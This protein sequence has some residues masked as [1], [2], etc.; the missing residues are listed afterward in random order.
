MITL[1]EHPLSPYSRKVKIALAEKG[2]QADIL[3]PDAFGTGHTAGLFQQASPRGEVPALVLEDGTA[4]FGSA[5]MMDY[6][7][8]RW[9]SPP[10]MPRDPLERARV[11]MIEEVVDTQ[12]EAIHWGLMEL[13]VFKRAEGA[14]A[15]TLDA[16]AR[17]QIDGIHGWLERQLG[18]KT[19]FSGEVCGRADIAVQTQ[20]LNASTF[21]V[22]PPEGSAFAAWLARMNA[23][24]HVARANA[25]ALES[26]RAVAE[27]LPDIVRSGAFKRQYR[28]HRLEWMIRSGGLSIVTDGM[29]SGTIRFST[30][31]R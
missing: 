7:E 26:A 30:E 11:R 19:W 15:E 18:E 21:G 13:H 8:D 2:V 24:P 31:I 4:L 9:P 27:G 14:L 3:T 20:C 29:E 6:L 22:E 12:M 16:R 5:V 10:L 17:A 23:R 1:F 28:D 25:Q